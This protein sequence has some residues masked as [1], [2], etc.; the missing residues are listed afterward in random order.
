MGETD[1]RYAGSREL[2]R[3]RKCLRCTFL[4]EQLPQKDLSHSETG[5]GPAALD[6]SLCADILPWGHHMVPP[7]VGRL[8]R[9]LPSPMTT[10]GSGSTY[11]S[12]IVCLA[13][14]GNSVWR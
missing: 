9:H 4:D 13:V 12:S 11:R 7:D 10:L 8:E 1:W 14:R 3:G 6:R 5:S 2:I